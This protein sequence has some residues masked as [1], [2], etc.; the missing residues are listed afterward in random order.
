[1]SSAKTRFEVGDGGAYVDASA[2]AKLILA[3][4]ESSAMRAILPHTPLVSSAILVTEFVRA[5]R[6][7]H[8]DRTDEALRKLELVDTVPIGG[9]VILAAGMIGAPILRS[10]DAVHLVTALMVKRH[11]SPLITYDRRLAAA[12]QAVGLEVASPR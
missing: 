6:R 2:F 12:A 3:E 4:P 9:D 8:P 11:V 7:H 5:V 1:M 10:L